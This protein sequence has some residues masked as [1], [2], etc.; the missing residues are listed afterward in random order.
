MKFNRILG[1]AALSLVMSAQA[2]AEDIN[3]AVIGPMTGQLANI[4]DQFKQGGFKLEHGDVEPPEVE[5]LQHLGVGQQPLQVRAVV[6][7]AVQAHDMGVPVAGR[8]LDH[9]QRVAPETQAHGL[10]IDGDLGPQVKVVGQVALM[11]IDGHAQV[12]TRR[13]QAAP[14]RAW[15]DR[16][17][18]SA[19]SS[20]TPRAMR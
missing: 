1:A 3:I 7:G 16:P 9:A 2:W 17:E 6:G 19:S 13:P 18:T 12:L 5:D 15:R 4:G 20:A 14:R 10:G 11:Q 8:Q